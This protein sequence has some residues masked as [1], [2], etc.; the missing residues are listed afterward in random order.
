MSAAVYL[1]AICTILLMSYIYRDEGYLDDA[2]VE[3]IP[4][5]DVLDDGEERGGE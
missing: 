1:I 5:G 2:F 3:Q 4:L